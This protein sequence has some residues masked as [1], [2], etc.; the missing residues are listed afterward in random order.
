MI[1]FKHC[2]VNTDLSKTVKI[3]K[4]HECAY[5]GERIPEGAQAVKLNFNYDGKLY[6][7]YLHHIGSPKAPAP[8]YD[9]FMGLNSTAAKLP[10]PQ[11]QKNN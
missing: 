3:R 8:C 11:A 4:S 1:A 10:A 2:D 9:W 5:C 7:V 6:P